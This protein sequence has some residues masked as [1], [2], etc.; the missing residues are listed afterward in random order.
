MNHELP[1]VQAKFTKG[2]EN[3]IANILWIIMEK[4]MAAHSSILA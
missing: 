2:K 4:E 3:Q 1:D